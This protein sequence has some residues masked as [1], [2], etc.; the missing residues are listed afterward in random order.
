MIATYEMGGEIVFGCITGVAVDQRDSD[1][2]RMGDAIRVGGA[3]RARN[4][5][6]WSTA[7]DLG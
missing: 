3:I 4:T 7:I 1:S 2:I 5:V 6:C